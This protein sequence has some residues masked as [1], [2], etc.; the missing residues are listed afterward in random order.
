MNAPGWA[1]FLLANAL[2]LARLVAGLAF[3]FVDAGWRLPLVVVGAATDLF[4]GAISRAF[5]GD[6]AFGRFLDPIADKAFVLLI[7]GT[8][9]YEGTIS[10]VQILLVG[11]RDWA[12]IGSAAWF[13][14]TGNFESLARMAPRWSGKFATAAQFLFLVSVLYYQHVVQPLFLLATA[15]SGVAAVDYLRKR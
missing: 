14:L 15:L 2:T 4:D 3:P 11:L 12:V 6:S 7:V 8:L 5:H 10:F 1:S 13:T 9:W